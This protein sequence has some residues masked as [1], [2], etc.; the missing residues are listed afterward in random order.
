MDELPTNTLLR[1]QN[2]E[3]ANIFG[4]SRDGSIFLKYPVDAE[5]KSEYEFLV[6]SVF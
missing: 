2:F 6:G 4:I 5:F 3:Y 1:I